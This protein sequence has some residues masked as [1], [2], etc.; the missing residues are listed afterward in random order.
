MWNLLFVGQLNQRLYAL[1][2]CLIHGNEDFQFVVKEHSDFG[3]D[4]EKRAGDRPEIA[5]NI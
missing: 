3:H 4:L 2:L 1:L 5:A